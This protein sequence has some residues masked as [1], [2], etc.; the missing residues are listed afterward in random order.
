MVAAAHPLA[1]NASLEILKMGGNA[2]DAAVAAAFVIGVVEPD[3]SG[4]GGGG[5][6]LIYLSKEKKPVYINYYQSAPL[7][8]DKLDYNSKTDNRT[9]KAILV[10]GTVAGLTTALEKYGTLPLS[11]V[12]AP[13]IKYAEEGFP[14]DATLAGI[15]LDHVEILQNYSSTA[16]TYLREGF[17]IMEGDTLIQEELAET[18]KLISIEGS[19]GFYSGSLAEEMV[20]AISAEGGIL[21]IDD[22]N[23]YKAQISEPTYGAYRGYKILSAH[24]PQSGASIVEALNILENEDL[25]KLGHYSTNV[26]TLNLM[27]E[28][29]RRVYADRSAFIEDPNFSYVPIDGLISKEYAQA[30]YEDINRNSTEPIDYRKTKP[31]NPKNFHEQIDSVLLEND[32]VLEFDGGHTTHLSVIDKD[33]N[34]VSLTQTIGTF[35]GSTFTANGVLFNNGMANFSSTSSINRKEPYKQ[36]RSSI[37]PTIIL[38]DD[39]PKIVVG[40]PGASRIIAIVVELIVNIIDFGMSAE[41]ANNFPRFFCQKFDDYLYVES[42]IPEDII[43]ELQK[44]GHNVRVLGDFDLFF[45]GAQLITV[46]PQT[47]IYYGSADRRRGGTAVGY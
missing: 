44:R 12:M 24:E 16:S 5:G 17:P 46:D 43:V 11:V 18:L 30:R 33:G 41:E 1:S 7:Q 21:T 34:A 29:F 40:S 22:F 6:M 25:K 45:G 47:G 27:A 14:I 15:I 10:P 42:R 13:A 2:V 26:E 39:M 35:F 38:K 4:L 20:N 8:V 9:V 36:P 19:N 32:K 3:G 31:G 37:S 23:N 28:T